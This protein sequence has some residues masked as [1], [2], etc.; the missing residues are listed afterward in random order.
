MPPGTLSGV[1]LAKLTGMGNGLSS[2]ISFVVRDDARTSNVLFQRSVTT[3]QAYNNYPGN[4]FPTGIDENGNTINTTY[5]DG[6]NGKSLYQDSSYGP[7]LPGI[8]SL[9]QARKVSFNRPYAVSENTYGIYGTAGPTLFNYDINLIRWLEKNGYDVSYC[10]D[11]DIHTADATNGRLAAGRH[12]VL[13]SG[14]H[15]EYW[16]WEMRDKVEAA[17]NRATQPLNLAFIGGNAAYWQIRFCDMPE[18]GACPENT[19][20]RTIIAYKETARTEDEAENDPAFRSPTNTDNHLI[21]NT[22]RRNYL[23]GGTVSKPS[24]DELIGVMYSE[25]PKFCC[26]SNE[27]IMSASCPNWICGIMIEEPPMEALV[28]YEA[29]RIHNESVYNTVRSLVTIAASPF[30][31][32]LGILQG[33]SNMTLYTR[34]VNNAR[35]FG[36]GTIQW[37]WGLD[38]FNADSTVGP[39]F[40]GQYKRETSQ[41]ITSRILS[42]LI[43]GTCS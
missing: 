42:C 16:S 22:W 1:Y 21:T 41:I 17:R 14:G 12:K 11:I 4:L 39:V 32:K 28:G 29:D 5:T 30:R 10:T 9:R 25:E 19:S 6:R 34:T 15:D 23:N 2:Y 8:S 40:R 37:A 24:E 18:S 7:Y 38:D 26:A 3:D 33:N 35:V 31:N 27:A 36:A 13:V 20:T 43:N